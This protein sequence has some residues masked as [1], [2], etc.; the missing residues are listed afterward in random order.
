MM[1]LQLF[2]LI[3]L[4]IIVVCI[5]ESYFSI[6]YDPELEKEHWKEI[7]NKRKKIKK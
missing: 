2:G 6:P 4:V 7:N 5:L 3:W 1:T